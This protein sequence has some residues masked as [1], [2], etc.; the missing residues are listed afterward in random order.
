M[1]AHDSD[2][3]MITQRTHATGRTH[4]RAAEL[5]ASRPHSWV[6]S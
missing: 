2:R 4:A 1:H 5:A 6:Y 3:H